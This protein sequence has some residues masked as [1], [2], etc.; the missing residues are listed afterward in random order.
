MALHGLPQTANT[1]YQAG[2]YVYGK[3]VVA[4]EADLESTGGRIY[5]TEDGSRYRDVPSVLWL[6]P[7]RSTR[8]C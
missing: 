5:V 2:L 8:D 4:T 6:Y 3:R 1:Q 7:D